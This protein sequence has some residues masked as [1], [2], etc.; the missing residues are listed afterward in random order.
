[1]RTTARW[2]MRIFPLPGRPPRTP[3][4]PRPRRIA[5]TIPVAATVTYTSSGFSALRAARERPQGAHSQPDSEPGHG[6]AAVRGMG[7]ARPSERRSPT[8]AA[9]GRRRLPRGAEGGVCRH[10]RPGGDRGRTSLRPV[11]DHQHDPSRAHS[12]PGRSR[13][14]RRAQPADDR[15]GGPGPPERAQC[16]SKKAPIRMMA[17]SPAKPKSTFDTARSFPPHLVAEPRQHERQR[18]ENEDGTHRR[19]R[20]GRPQPSPA[21]SSR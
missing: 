1:M 10:W 9:D 6:A 15:A 12:R 19:L 11:R 8:G 17:K 7:S 16:R 5:E 20:P 18:E 21:S 4:A 3:Y 2:S 14:R 13:G